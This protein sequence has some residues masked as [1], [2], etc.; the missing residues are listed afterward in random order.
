LVAAYAQ[1]IFPWYSEGQPILWHSPDPRFVLTPERL[2][3]PQSL[4]KTLRRGTYDVR[5]DTSFD[6]VVAGCAGAERPGQDGTWITDEMSRAYARLHELGIAHSAESWRDG[7][8]QGG[9]YGVSLGKAFF[10]ESMFARAPD[11]S[12]T[13]F[14]ILA[15]ALFARGFE[16]IDCQ[17]ETDHLRRFGAEAWPRSRYLAALSHALTL[18]HEPGHWTEWSLSRD[19]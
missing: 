15:Q 10:G 17:Q 11:A 12:K 14:A 5:L 18:S 16:F 19:S 1:G 8:L 9:L 6:E 4:K 3:L 13:A 7:K 2:H